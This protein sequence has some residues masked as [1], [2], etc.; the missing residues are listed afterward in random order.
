MFHTSTWAAQAAEDCTE[1]CEPPE[2]KQHPAVARVFQ[3]TSVKPTQD[4]QSLLTR[5]IMG[6][7]DED[8]MT[9]SNASAYMHDTR[10]RSLNSNA[11][12][13]SV[14]D[15]TSDTGLTSPAR[16]NT[17]SPPIPEMAILPLERHGPEPE[18]VP[19]NG[20]RPSLINTVG[21]TE[22]PRKRCIQFACSS[23]PPV[24]K[25]AVPPTQTEKNL[26]A[27]EAPR[28]PCIK[29]ACAARP[30][31]TQHKTQQDAKLSPTS[32]YSGLLSPKKVATLSGG[33]RASSPRLTHSSRP[34]NEQISSRPKFFRAN[35]KDLV[36]DA[37]Q[38]H[39]FASE[40][41]REE[42]WIRQDSIS[43]TRLTINDTL[44]KENDIIRIAT[45]AEEEA[46]LEDEAAEAAIDDDELD[47]VGDDDGDDDNDDESEDEDHDDKNS[48]DDDDHRAALY[49][50][51]D[52][53]HTDEETGFADSDSE[54]EDDDNMALWTPSRVMPR[55]SDVAIPAMRRPPLQEHLSDSSGDG[56]GDRSVRRVRSRRVKPYSDAPDLPDSTDFVCGTLDE[57]RPLEEAYLSCLAAR[58][59]EK[60]RV[61]PQDID[62][63]FPASDPDD[64]DERVYN[65]IHH[66]SDEGWMHGEMEGLQNCADRPRRR[67][68]EQASPRKVHSPP[69]RLHSPPPK[70]KPRGRSPRGLFDRQSPRRMRSPAPR[71]FM[72]TPTGSPRNGPGVSI[73][74]GGRPGLTQT[75]SLPRPAAMFPHVRS[76]RN[77]KPNGDVH[78]RNAIDIVKGLEKKRQRRK[79]KFHQKYC[80]R[81]RRGQ[82]PERRT[83]PGKGAERMKELGLLMAGKK[84][85]A[86]YVLSI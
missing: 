46:E 32:D 85:Q 21:S 13:V 2:L 55:R 57:D 41:K 77:A 66:G 53:Y 10:R 86:D 11:S 6:Q 37:S 14:A 80:D 19:P 64:D 74:L 59:N 63:S 79:E 7:S 48:D 49:S 18:S 9:E 84:G 20:V 39:E 61:I 62:P 60:L 72:R 33:S 78:M 40:V 76:N 27:V 12:A 69:R 30:A 24:Q 83:Q 26:S 22:P 50:E 45:E 28:R 15:L 82:I 54:E 65:R 8:V 23:R 47:D 36:N 73:Q 5:A 34:T 16:T 42:D 31:S 71:A 44:S 52:G 68:S 70:P 51:S 29:F 17:P 1:P 58:R 81:A 67:Q 75:K 43:K 38:F 4:Q 25:Q 35:S 3:R 56:S